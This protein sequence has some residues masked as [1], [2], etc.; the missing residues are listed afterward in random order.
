MLRARGVC[1]RTGSEAGGKAIAAKAGSRLAGV[2]LELG[3]KSANIVF[4]DADLDRAEAG[5]L[6]GIFAAAGQTCVAGLWPV[7][8]RTSL[9]S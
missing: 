6:A 7:C 4:A 2:T 8:L 1:R 9:I 3:G 5:V